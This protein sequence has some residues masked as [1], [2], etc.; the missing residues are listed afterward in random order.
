[1]LISILAFINIKKKISKEV[2]FNYL[3]LLLFTLSVSLILLFLSS[4]YSPEKILVIW[5]SLI[6]MTFSIIIMS[7]LFKNKFNIILGLIIILL[8]AIMFSVLLLIFSKFFFN[9]SETFFIILTALGAVFFGVYLI[10]HTQMLIIEKIEVDTDKYIIA[11]M[12][13]YSDIILIFINLVCTLS[14][15]LQ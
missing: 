12:Q 3:L 2:P 13:I 9:E 11:S 1:M 4:A 14:H 8:I 6:F 5:L 7:F 15:K 10:F